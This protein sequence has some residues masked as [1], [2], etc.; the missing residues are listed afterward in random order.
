MNGLLIYANILSQ[1]LNGFESM[2][3]VLNTNILTVLENSFFSHP[4]GPSS[5]INTLVVAYIKSSGLGHLTLLSFIFSMFG[6]AFGFFFVFTILKW[7]LN[8]VT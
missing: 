1:W 4:V 8:L 3:D 6:V 5:I 2:W 7:F